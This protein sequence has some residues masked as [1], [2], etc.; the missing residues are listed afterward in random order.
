MYLRPMRR[1]APLLAL[2]VLAA[3]CRSSA[4]YRAGA[5]D[6]AYAPVDAGVAADSAVAALVAPYA[7]GLREEMDEVVAH[8][9]TALTKGGPESPLGN[10]SADAML[11]EAER[12]LGRDLAFSVGN[13]GGLRRPIGPGPVTRGDVFELM[14]FE[15]SLVVLTLTGVEV[16]SLAQQLAAAGGE[17]VS[18][19]SFV[20]TPQGRASGV[21]VGE[22]PLD[23]AAAY[24][25]VTHNYLAFGGG[26]MPALWSAQ[27]SEDVGLTLRDAFL[28]YFA[29][30]GTL[31][32]T[33]EGRITLE[34][35]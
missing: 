2:L 21:R 8:A 25:V 29:R 13:A 4:P 11:A 5:V 24:D 15:N 32:A 35:P 3:G 22:A 26:D 30:M 20:I 1:L 6:V 31:S 16:D 18:G 27:R 19:L 34:T 14:P 33:V 10:L 28:A 17:P 23:P 7:E 9:P 12:A